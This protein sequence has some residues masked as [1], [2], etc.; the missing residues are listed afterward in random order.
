LRNTCRCPRE[1]QSRLESLQEIHKSVGCQSEEGIGKVCTV[2]R[3]IFRILEVQEHGGSSRLPHFAQGGAGCKGDCPRNA[4]QNA[5]RRPSIA[6][7]QLKGRQRSSEMKV[8]ALKMASTSRPHGLVRRRGEVLV[9]WQK[10]S[11][12]I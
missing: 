1:V 10:G 12:Q 7:R 3:A 2:N 8:R 11:N 6:R 5:V 4:Q 9:E